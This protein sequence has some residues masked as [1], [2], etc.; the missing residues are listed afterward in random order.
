MFDVCYASCIF[1]LFC[2]KSVDFHARQKICE[3]NVI[4]PISATWECD[5]G[6]SLRQKSTDL[7]GRVIGASCLFNCWVPPTLSLLQNS[8]GFPQD[9]HRV[10]LMQLS[11]CYYDGSWPARRH[12]QYSHF[13]IECYPNEGPFK[14]ARPR[15]EGGKSSKAVIAFTVIE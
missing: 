6:L 13:I 10:Y 2:K 11:T 3:T 4:V 7:T 14:F 8:T 15:G 12:A 1:T 9:H 5:F